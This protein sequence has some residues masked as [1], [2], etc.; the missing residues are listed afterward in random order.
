[1]KPLIIVWACCM[2]MNCSSLMPSEKFFCTTS[3][4]RIPDVTIETI[5][6][7]TR[8]SDEG[9][10]ECGTISEPLFDYNIKYD[11]LSHYKVVVL[12]YVVFGKENNYKY[13]YERIDSVGIIRL[14]IDREHFPREL[15]GKKGDD[16]WSNKRWEECPLPNKIVNL[17]KKDFLKRMKYKRFFFN[18]SVLKQPIK[19]VTTQHLYRLY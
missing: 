1:M 9:C 13:Q 12:G 15:Y 8:S 19:G 10:I 18:K 4:N 16:D 17:I 11:T 6:Y 3:T 2:L 14:V 5:T 7:R